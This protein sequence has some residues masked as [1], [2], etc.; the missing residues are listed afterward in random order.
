MSGPCP[1]T[2]PESWLNP[3]PNPFDLSAAQGSKQKF[4]VISRHINIHASSLRYTLPERIRIVEF[5][6]RGLSPLDNSNLPI[7]EN[8]KNYFK[9]AGLVRPQVEAIGE[10]LE[11]EIR[12]TTSLI[13]VQDNYQDKV[14]LHIDRAYENQTPDEE[15]VKRAAFEKDRQAC[16]AGAEET[17]MWFQHL[18]EE[19]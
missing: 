13:Q 5:W 10:K 1:N 15:M 9:M 8:D 4:E 19:S 18:Q 16:R 3:E 2:Y 11:Q 6:I 12:S 17:R 7:F 14:N